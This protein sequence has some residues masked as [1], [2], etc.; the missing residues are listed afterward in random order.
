MKRN[1][2]HHESIGDV[3]W[4]EQHQCW[5]AK[6]DIVGCP[7]PLTILASESGDPPI[8]FISTLVDTIRNDE[9]RYRR[10]AADELLHVYND[11]WRHY[12]DDGFEISPETFMQRLS[13]KMLQIEHLT[14]SQSWAAVIT[15]DPANMFTEHDV[16]VYVSTDLSSRGVVPD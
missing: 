10:I 13:L 6:I 12:T 15:Y 7:T 3:P 9:D 2:I 4:H 8:E 1:D 14:Q 11:D 16:A 5:G